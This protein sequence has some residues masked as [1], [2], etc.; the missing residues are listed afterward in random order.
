MTAA[1]LA[2]ELH[3]PL[4]TTLYESIIGKFMGETASRFRVI[5]DAMSVTKG[6]YLFD[7]FD[8]I[9]TQRTTGNDVGEI[10]RI[11]NSFLMFLENDNSQSIIIA[12]TNH[13]SLLDNALFRRFDDVI[14]Y[15]LPDAKIIRKLIEIRLVTF[16]IGWKDWSRIID[17]AEGLTQAEIVRATDEAAKQAILSNTKQVSE[18][19][20]ILAILERKDIT[21]EQ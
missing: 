16:D 3:L 11:L 1:A 21:F 17:A 14:K 18:E 15:K 20:L 6:V 2:G 8:A 7:E 12:A 10:R 4:F 5:F 9:G 19:T 13:P